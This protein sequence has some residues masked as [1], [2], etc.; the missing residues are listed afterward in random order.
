LARVAQPERVADELVERIGQ[1]AYPVGT[2]LPS[3]RMLA[4]EF[5]VSRPVVREALRMLAMLQ[6]IDVQVGRGAYVSAT[7]DAGD[8]ISLD[9]VESLTDIVDV[10]QILEVGAL[11][12]AARRASSEAKAAVAE[13]LAQLEAAVNAQ[14]PTSRLDTRLH[15]AI[16]EASGSENLTAIWRN[17]QSKV[18]RTIR[19]SPH[20]RVMSRELLAEH[21]KL[22]R[23]ITDAATAEA[24]AAAERLYEDNRRFFA[25][26][27]DGAP[28]DKP[29]RRTVKAAS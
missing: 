13:A 14:L 7:P 12:L 4:V 1:G 6:L 8:S 27:G 5:G 15:D 9:D 3:E 20:G 28:S 25:E 19:V 16:I 23:G 18:A 17:I 10:R 22:A 26:L 11:T 24:I 2:K 29:R 21:R